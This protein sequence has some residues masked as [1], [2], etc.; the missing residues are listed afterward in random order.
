M[1]RCDPFY[2]WAA[3]I[4]TH[5]PHLSKPQHTVLAL[6]SF[7]MVI[8]HSCALTAVAGFM[9]DLFGRKDN[10]VRQRLREWCYDAAD[11]QGTHRISLDVSACFVPLL[12]WVLSL[13][14][15]THLA[16][17]LD[18][19]SLGDRFVVLV[20][21][22]LYRGCALPVAW[23]V[24]PANVPGEWRRE[25]LWLLRVL[26]P[27]IAR[28][29]FVV[30]MADRGLYARWLF[31]R[32]VRLGWHPILRV[33]GRGSFRP[34][35]PGQQFRPLPTFLPQAGTQWRGSGIAFKTKGC[36]LA[37]TLLAIW[38]EGQQE[39][40]F[41]LTDLPPE[42]ADAAW[43]GLRIW[44]EQSFKL[45]KRGGWQWQ[46][47][48]MTDPERAERLWIAVAVATLWLVSVGGEA[49]PA[50]PEST[51]PDV[52]DMLPDP[53]ATQ[54]LQRRATQLRLVSAFRRGWR[55]IIVA[56]LRHAALPSGQLSPEPWPTFS[57]TRED[58]PCC[59]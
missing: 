56:L 42:A 21:S 9:A 58:V 28:S 36:H 38:Q 59:S 43:Y 31:R 39:P 1:T 19:T 32:I 5:L 33:H 35:G 27:A 3:T 54:R 50:L 16:L 22:V 52:A 25:W 8:A 6:W 4:A 37:C 41:L 29:F 11:K 46:R 47:T 48:R 49:D 17:A 45:M 13:W 18:A 15:G 34:D 23:A 12:R 40:W 10:T 20:V 24:L 55:R 57:Q 44:I 26:Q 7:G 2:Q 30:V 53:S 14:Q 51:I